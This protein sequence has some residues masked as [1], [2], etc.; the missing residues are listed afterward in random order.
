VLAALGEV[1]YQGYATIE[2]D[3]VA[4][5]GSPADDLAESRRVLASAGLAGVG[6]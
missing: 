5:R 6:P 3:R 4:G 2:Q 1:G